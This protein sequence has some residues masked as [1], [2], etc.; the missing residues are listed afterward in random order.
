M[1]QEYFNF[2][3]GL[4]GRK[5]CCVSRVYVSGPLN[6]IISPSNSSPPENSLK[7]E[8]L[9]PHS[10]PE[11]SEKDWLCYQVMLTLWLS[12]KPPL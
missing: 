9:V 10:R 8:N 2:H 11:K 6:I 4:N 1:S 5:G 7:V 3:Q 12:L